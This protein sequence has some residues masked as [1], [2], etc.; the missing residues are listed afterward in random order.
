MCLKKAEDGKGWERSHCFQS[1]ISEKI[2]NS[3]P[4]CYLKEFGFG[5]FKFDSL[6]IV[7]T[8]FVLQRISK[9]FQH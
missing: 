8:G 2:T 4:T 1:I 7:I 5:P 6:M 3:H 9:A